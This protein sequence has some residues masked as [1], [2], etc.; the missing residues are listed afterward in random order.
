MRK[1]NPKD[2]DYKNEKLINY[3]CTNGSDYSRMY[4]Y[5]NKLRSDLT[6]CEA[7]NVTKVP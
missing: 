2:Q 7:G 3:M 1:P 6:K 4:D 5:M